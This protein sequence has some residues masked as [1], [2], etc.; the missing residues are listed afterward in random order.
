MRR[1]AEIRARESVRSWKA[2]QHQV[3]VIT[4]RGEYHA[5]QLI[6]CSGA[7]TG[8]LLQQLPISLT[9]TR[10]VLAW[11]WPKRPELFELGKL[12]VWAIDSLDGG[13]YYG[14]PMIPY[15]PGFKLAHH[16]TGPVA[17]PDTLNR[18]ATADD[19][20]S[21]RTAL[22][23]HIPEADG[24]LTALR[25]CMYTNTPD[26]DFIIDY[27]PAYPRVQIAGGF[28]GHGFK[29]ASVIG[30]ILADRVT[31]GETRWDLEFLSITNRRVTSDKVRG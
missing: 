30:E 8:K 22:K 18:Q 13:I 29:F 21:I 31:S 14:F 20:T 4:D 9:V 6:F 1:G 10:Q 16:I 27:H 23:K 25:I 5:D 17:D 19:V 3:T 24:P 15:V 11:V 26:R 12:P 7:W 28:S 2:D